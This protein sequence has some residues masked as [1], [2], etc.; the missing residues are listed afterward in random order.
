MSQSQTDDKGWDDASKGTEHCTRNTCQ[1]GA[2]KG[3]RVNGDRSRG[4]LCD[5]DED[6]ELSE[7][8]QLVDVDNLVLNQRNCCI[9]AAYAEQ[10]NLNEWQKITEIIRSSLMPP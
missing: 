5:G 3:C 9:S 8:H 7:G 2:D 6:G 10:T 1:T 4:H